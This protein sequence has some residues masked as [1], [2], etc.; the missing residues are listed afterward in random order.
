[1]TPDDETRTCHY[2]RKRR[3]DRWE[4]ACTVCIATQFSQC[5]T[6][7]GLTQ[8]GA[9]CDDCNANRQQL[10]DEYNVKPLYRKRRT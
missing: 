5:I 6:C 2:C 10:L 3:I 1:M 7:G 4:I 8:W 9:W